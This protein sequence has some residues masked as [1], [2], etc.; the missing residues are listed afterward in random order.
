MANVGSGKQFEYSLWYHDG[1]KRFEKDEHVTRVLIIT[2]S[3]GDCRDSHPMMP[4]FINLLSET[5]EKFPNAT[6]VE[7]R[8]VVPEIQAAQATIP[9]IL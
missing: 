4:E 2:P 3:F 7:L 9:P 1:H 8:T 6:E 5:S